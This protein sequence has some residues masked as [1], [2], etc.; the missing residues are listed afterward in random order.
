MNKKLVW[1]G[2]LLVLLGAALCAVCVAGEGFDWK[3]LSTMPLVTKTHSIDGAVS[4][5]IVEGGE[6]SVR[7]LPAGDGECRVVCTE[8]E[9]SSLTYDVS[10]TDGVLSVRLRDQQRWYERIGIFIASGGVELYLPQ[11]DYESLSV[12]TSSGSVHVPKDFS[13]D[14]AQLES[15]SGSVNFSAGVKGA[16]TAKTSSG[17]ISISDTAPQEAALRS[18]SGSIVLE[19]VGTEKALKASSAS[20]RVSLT[21]VSCGALA[22]ET[23]SGGIRLTDVIAAEFMDAR[24]SSGSVRLKRCDG[25]ELSIRTS[26]GSV[27]G[28]L[29]SDKIFL[30]DS[31][32]GSVHVPQTTTGGICAV[33]TSSGSI[34]LEYE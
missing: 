1:I 31:S 18:Q 27:S 12:R 7:L 21:N 25:A 10:L 6:N 32:S 13:F 8:N 14:Q 29:L 17:R 5:I 3:K 9:N 28:T 30:A 26:S 4:S 24:S 33:T 23:S 19:R 20:G 34:K 16:L 11:G 2:C 15:A 22:V